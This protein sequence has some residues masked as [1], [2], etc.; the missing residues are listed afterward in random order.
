MRRTEIGR[1]SSVLPDTY[2][3]LVKRHPL[4]RIRDE[5][6]LN[7]AQAV[8]D[9][10]LRE[11]LDE[12]GLAYLE[13]LSDLVI[14]YELEHHALAPLTPHEL[15]AHMLDERQMSQADLVR[16]TGLPKATVSN[17][18]SGKRRFTV[19]QMHSVAR[20]FGLPGTLFMPGAASRSPS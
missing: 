19:G 1:R 11:E 2:F 4:A 13:A 20:V 12:G 15:L 8:V 5:K 9:T 7:A 10:L 14:V 6:E 17:L 3:E 18:V 16:A